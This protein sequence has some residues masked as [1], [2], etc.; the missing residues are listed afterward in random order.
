MLWTIGPRTWSLRMRGPQLAHWG[1]CVACLC[2]ASIL[3]CRSMPCPHNR[4]LTRKGRQTLERLQGCT[5]ID[6]LERCLEVIKKSPDYQ[7]LLGLS[8]AMFESSYDFSRPGQP[9]G[10]FVDDIATNRKL[11]IAHELYM[12]LH[13]VEWEQLMGDYFRAA[14]GDGDLRAAECALVRWIVEHRNRLE[15]LP[16]R[17]SFRRLSRRFTSAAWQHGDARERGT[18][19]Y[20]LVKGRS[21]LGLT[22]TVVVRVLG[23]PDFREPEAFTYEFD[24]GN[25]F[26]VLRPGDPRWFFEGYL[27]ITFDLGSGRAERVEVR[28][29]D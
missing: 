21:L 4:H 24:P 26:G 6:E 28:E 2:I 3:G 8:C 17:Q 13:S 7:E 16:R 19:V 29:D 15:W 27:D 10:S 12:V 20:D 18:M 1:A 23:E 9:G 14:R 22:R 25:F 11:R 5:E